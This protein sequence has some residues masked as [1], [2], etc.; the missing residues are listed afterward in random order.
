MRPIG[1]AVAVFN[2]RRPA[3]SGHI[4]GYTMISMWRPGTTNLQEG[5][6]QG[7]I[8]RLSEGCDTASG[9]YL[10]EVAITE[11]DLA[12]DHARDNE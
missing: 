5:W 11:D 4:V 7:Y 12:T 1:Q 6:V 2:G 8:V 3:V 9:L 10:R